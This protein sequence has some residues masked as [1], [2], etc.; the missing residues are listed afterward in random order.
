VGR[1][2]HVSLLPTNGFSRAA[3]E[4]VNDQHAQFWTLPADGARIAA[5]RICVISRSGTGSGLNRRT[6]AV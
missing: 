2:D 5:S 4:A 1:G 3:L 6:A